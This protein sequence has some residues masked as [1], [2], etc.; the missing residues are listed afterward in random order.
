M[1]ALITR[2]RR[3]VNDPASAVQQFTDDELQDVL[4]ARRDDV[5]YVEL[6]GVEYVAPGGM[7]QYLDYWAPNGLGDWEADAE[8]TDGTWAVV[9]PATSDGL[10]GHWTF[11]TNQTPPVYMRGRTYDLNAAAADVL[12]AWAVVDAADAVDWQ[13]GDVRESR[14]KL[15]ANR[16][17][18]AASY[19]ARQ[20]PTIMRMVR[21]DQNG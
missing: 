1:T 14:S 4:D 11:A 17:T 15:Q 9:T 16:L 7:V 2:L 12:D 8:L 3:M 13:E 19:R 6:T 20:R 18:A 10:K 21:S 5:S